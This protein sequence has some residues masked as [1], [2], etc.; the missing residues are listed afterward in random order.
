MSDI[1][2][3]G[4]PI[5][6]YQSKLFAIV[7][8]PMEINGEILEFE[9]AVRPPGVRLIIQSR[10]KGLVYLTREYRSE[11]ATWDWRLPGGKV[12]NSIAEYLPH[13]FRPP[14]ED[15]DWLRDKILEAA[16]REAL[17]EVG[18]EIGNVE[19]L[20]RSTCGATVNWDLHYVRATPNFVGSNHPEAG[21]QIEVHAVLWSRA[22]ELA[23]NGSFAEERSA[24]WLRRSILETWGE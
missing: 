14:K 17:E 9:T 21:E 15:G 5:V 3:A 4:Q 1:R 19:I 22:L 6:R 16:E 23:D 12:V 10:D 11:L 20:G 18:I 13:Y 8:T 2:Q 24:I 7:C